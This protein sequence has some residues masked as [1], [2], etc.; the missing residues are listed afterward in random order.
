M[1][2]DRIQRLKAKVA[3]LEAQLAHERNL[4]LAG[5][6][7]QFGFEVVSEF[8]AAVKAAAGAAGKAGR[9]KAGAAGSGRRKRAVI[10]VQTRARVKTLAEAG[11]TGAE[12]AKAVGISLPSVQNIKKALGL[13][14]NRGAKAKVAPAKQAPGKQAPAKKPAA[15]KTA[16]KKPQAQKASPK[17]APAAPQPLPPPAPG[18]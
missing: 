13:V 12:I 18:R 15:K 9:R 1:A 4:E 6:P 10:T 14:K 8:L 17:K 3:R 7:K 2:L 11:K 5:L 16:A